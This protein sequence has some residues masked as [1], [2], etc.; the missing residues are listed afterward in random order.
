MITITTII[1]TILTI[2]IIITITITIIITTIIMYY[3]YC[4]YYTSRAITNATNLSFFFDICII[5]IT[6]INI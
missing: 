3:C 6:H 1:I 4:D 5:I 2:I